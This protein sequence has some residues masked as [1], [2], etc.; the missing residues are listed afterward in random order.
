MGMFQTLFRTK[1]QD[2][3]SYGKKIGI[4]VKVLQSTYLKNYSVEFTFGDD[5]PSVDTAKN[6]VT[7]PA[8]II[9]KLASA[10]LDGIVKEARAV[11]LLYHEAVHA[12]VGNK[13]NSGDIA[14][15]VL[16]K[17]AK[18]Y[19]STGK[20]IDGKTIPEEGLD[21]AVTEAMA[22]YVHRRIFSWWFAHELL[23]QFA[24]EMMGVP[25]PNHSATLKLTGRDLSDFN[26]VKTILSQKNFGNSYHSTVKGEQKNMQI[27]TPMHQGLR[28]YCD[29]EILEGKINDVAARFVTDSPIGGN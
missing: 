1:L 14:F 5:D 8:Q 15:A 16:H 19:Y 2:L 29:R 20:F 10:K 7:L 4:P 9:A 3:I 21:S 24:Y 28:D 6:V 26:L 23:T 17:Q 27:A 11:G 22:Q 25:N 18:A 13:L 12:F